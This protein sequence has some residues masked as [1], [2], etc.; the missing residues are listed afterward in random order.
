MSPQGK[1]HLACALLLGGQGTHCQP[2]SSMALCKG[3]QAVLGTSQVHPSPSRGE[4]PLPL[5]ERM[6]EPGS[7]L[8]GGKD[9]S[10]SSSVEEGYSGASRERRGCLR[11]CAES[12]PFPGLMPISP[13]CAPCAPTFP[14]SS[15]NV[16]CRFP[17]HG[18]AS[19][20][21]CSDHG[22]R[23]SSAGTAS[24]RNPG[25]SGEPAQ[26]QDESGSLTSPRQPLAQLILALPT[27][28]PFDSAP[29]A[30]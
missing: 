19:A 12:N 8:K 9:L 14:Q 17:M 13:T 28:F 5:S 23:V 15:A 18:K 22:R 10:G 3:S 1:T 4:I 7:L 2:R 24:A 16:G 27:R 25:A 11:P 20:Q 29:G 6:A 30:L 26:A 21:K